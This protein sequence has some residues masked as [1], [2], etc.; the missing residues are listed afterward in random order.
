MKMANKIISNDED[1]KA[2]IRYARSSLRTMVT[3]NGCSKQRRRRETANQHHQDQN[4]ESWAPIHQGTVL[5]TN[6]NI[7]TAR[8]R[9]VPQAFQHPKIIACVP[10]GQNQEPSEMWSC[11]S[12]QDIL[13]GLWWNT[14]RGNRKNTRLQDEE[15]HEPEGTNNSS[16]RTHWYEKT[17][18]HR[19]RSECATNSLL[20][21]EG[22]SGSQ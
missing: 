5:G 2:E 16:G 7:Q 11:S 15:T 14:H 10:L 12:V 21:G 20:H 17:Q 9:D 4:I 18:D 13:L 8:N 19:G 1:K 22:R 3:K 6:T